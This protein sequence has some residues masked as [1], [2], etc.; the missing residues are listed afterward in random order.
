MKL[1]ELEAGQQLGRFAL[2]VRPEFVA[3]YVAAT[4]DGSVARPFAEGQPVPPMAVIA[5]GLGKLIDELQLTGGTIH[6]GQEVEFFRPVLGGERIYA[7]A[8]LTA[9]SVRRDSRFATILTRFQ[10][11]AGKRVASALSTIVVPVEQTP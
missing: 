8:E 4:A 6:A 9:T 1:A 7:E 11:S 3:R 2:D 5:T 10:D